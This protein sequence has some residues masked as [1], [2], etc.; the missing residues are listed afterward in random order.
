MDAKTYAEEHVNKTVY[1]KEEGEYTRE[2]GIVVGYNA[3]IDSLIVELRSFKGGWRRLTKYDK[4]IG[5]PKEAD[6][7]YVNLNEIVP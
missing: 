3:E 4:I 6:Y 7:W 2:K 1:F 5:D